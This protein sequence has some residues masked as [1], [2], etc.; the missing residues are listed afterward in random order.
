MG[1]I[2]VAVLDILKVQYCRKRFPMFF[3]TV[4]QVYELLYMKTF[5]S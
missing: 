1:I 3:V 2:F 4:E 5:D